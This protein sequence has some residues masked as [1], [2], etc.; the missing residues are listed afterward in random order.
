[1]I[2]QQT[3]V[4]YVVEAAI[5]GQA[6]LWMKLYDAD[7]RVVEWAK[8]LFYIFAVG[9]IGLVWVIQA[10]IGFYNPWLIIQYIALVILSTYLYNQQNTIKN[11]VCLAFL[12]VFL[13]SYYWELP[14]HLAEYIQ[15]G[16]YHPAQLK[17]LWRLFP[18]FFFIPKGMITKQSLKPLTG[19]A[20]FSIGLMAYRS[21]RYRQPLQDFHHPV[22]R[23]VCL[24]VLVYAITRNHRH[25]VE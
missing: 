21:Q 15:I 19:G 23:L 4:G 18:L 10:E 2:W 12:T 1:M 16:F 5:L 13:N 22:N 24:L 17:Q 7:I 9:S 11:A 3:P 14:L 25:V 6:Y 20:L 8:Y